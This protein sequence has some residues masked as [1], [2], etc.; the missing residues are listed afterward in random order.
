MA[1][2]PDK[3]GIK[4]QIAADVDSKYVL[5]G[6][7]YLGY[8]EER[9]ENLSLSEYVVLYLIESFENKGRNITADNFFTTLNLSQMLKIK[10]TSLTGT[11][12]RN[13]KKVSAFVKK[14]KMPLY[15]A[16]L[17]EHDDIALKVNRGKNSKNVLL[18]I[19][20]HPSVDMDSNHPKR[21]P[22]T[23]IL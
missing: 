18:L 9:P 3:F 1:G 22:E 12:K 10:N 21:L 7:P 16:L 2:K 13:R 6:F 19:S 14:V 8:D 11:M 17:L 15:D 20:L 4:F 23:I 5:N